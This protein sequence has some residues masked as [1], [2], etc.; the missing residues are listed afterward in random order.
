MSIITVIICA[1]LGNPNAEEMISMASRE[2][3]LVAAGA[4]RESVALARDW[5]TG[6]W[7]SVAH[8]EEKWFCAEGT[9]P[10]DVSADLVFIVAMSRVITRSRSQVPLLEVFAS[11]SALPFPVKDD[12]V[13]FTC[14]D[15]S[16]GDD[17]ALMVASPSPA[18]L[19]DTIRVHVRAYSDLFAVRPVARTKPLSHFVARSQGCCL[20]G[21]PSG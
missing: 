3:I 2:P 20:E 14:S 21:G 7:I 12:S 1:K 4:S 9:R 16:F 17:F 11:S 8:F 6:N 10:G 18:D 13:A 19:F 15:V 5:H